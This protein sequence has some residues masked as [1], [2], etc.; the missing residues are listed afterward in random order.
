MEAPEESAEREIMEESETEEWVAPSPD[1]VGHTSL[2]NPPHVSS[3]G[4]SGEGVAPR[5]LMTFRIRPCWRPLI[6]RV[7]GVAWQFGPIGWGV[8][9]FG[10]YGPDWA[11]SI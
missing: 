1:A 11:L 6:R 5:I 8:R 3:Q 4:G 2:L 10:P 7:A 9:L